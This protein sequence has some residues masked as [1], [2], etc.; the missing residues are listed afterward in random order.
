[1]QGIFYAIEHKFHDDI[2][3]CSLADELAISKNYLIKRFKAETGQ[4]PGQYL[5]QYRL[6]RAAMLLAEH[7]LSVQDIANAVGIPDANYFT[8]LFK[9][10]YHM[11]P[12]Q[13]RK[14]RIV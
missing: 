6:K 7:E 1:M 5:T 14:S 9:K 12:I 13:Y 11:T 8:K 10:Y 2:S 3:I 4:T